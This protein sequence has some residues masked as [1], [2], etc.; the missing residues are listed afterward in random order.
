MDVLEPPQETHDLSVSMKAA[1][2]TSIPGLCY[3]PPA[4]R[5]KQL[6]FESVSQSLGKLV[7]V[8][9]VVSEEPPR[10]FVD[11]PP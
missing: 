7:C 2:F 1:Q 6:H 9:D 3:A 5:I 11:K 8:I 4:V 10:E